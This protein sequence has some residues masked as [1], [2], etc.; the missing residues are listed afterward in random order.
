MDELDQLHGLAVA[1]DAEA[2]P[3][4]PEAP[5]LDAAGQPL[6]PA[7]DFNQEATGAVDMFAALV[8]GWCPKAETIW[9]PETKGRIS[10]ALAPVMEKYGFTFGAAPPELMLLI[11][12]GPPLW[13]SS[14]LVADQINEERA[15][16]AEQAGAPAPQIAPAPEKHEAPTAPVHP[17]M[18]LYV[19]Q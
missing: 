19:R 3:P 9:T 18:G 13:Q 17:Q 1:A 8:V 7:P 11:M 2:I 5:A 4:Q 15:K 16:K 12:A 14:R 6:P 10:G